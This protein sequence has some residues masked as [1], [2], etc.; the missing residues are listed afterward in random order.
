MKKWAIYTIVSAMIMFVILLLISGNIYAIILALPVS[1]AYV[2]FFN[3]T[4]RG[5]A[6]WFTWRRVGLEFENFLN[7]KVSNNN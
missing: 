4:E 1:F 3:A 7:G 2:W 5:A 6:W